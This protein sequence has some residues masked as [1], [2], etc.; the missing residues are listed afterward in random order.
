MQPD[1]SNRKAWNCE[2]LIFT[3]IKLPHV[4]SRVHAWLKREGKEDQTSRPVEFEICFTAARPTTAFQ[5]PAK[6]RHN[7]GKNICK[8]K[9]ESGLDE[10][11][12]KAATGA[13]NGGIA[14]LKF[15]LAAYLQ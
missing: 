12:G 8:K 5:F 4:R 14:T 7:D 2:S 9:L 6:T 13:N 10:A 1:L 15:T 11:S 3:R